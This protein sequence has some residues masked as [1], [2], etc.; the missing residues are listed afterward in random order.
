VSCRDY[1][2]GIRMP[3]FDRYLFA[4]FSGGGESCAAQHGLRL[5]RSLGDNAPSPVSAIT[6]Q[7]FNRH[8]LRD[9]IVA[10]LADASTNAERV[11]FGLDFQFAW[12]THLRKFAKVSTMPWR[13]AL[14]AL[15]HGLNGVP[16][17]DIPRR[18]CKAFNRFAEANVFW[19]PLRRKAQGY[20]I[21]DQPLQLLDNERYR[22]TEDK[23]RTEGRPRI[24]RSRIDPGCADAVGGR[25]QGVVGGQ[26]ICGLH[27]LALMLGIENVAWWPFDG[28]DINNKTYDGKHVGVETYPRL[29][30]DHGWPVRPFSVGDRDDRDA[31]RT[32]RYVQHADRPKIKNRLPMVPDLPVIMSLTNWPHLPVSQVRQEGWILGGTP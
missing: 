9:R 32:C 15:N 13:Q 22:L 12:P 19:T 25:G 6:G 5:W 7:R 29:Y 30:A 26:T 24:E 16:P 1:A 14:S 21:P 4:D 20:G 23:L 28:L 10:E 11:I 17:L 2:K 3:L 18:Y 31:W 27:Q 8:S